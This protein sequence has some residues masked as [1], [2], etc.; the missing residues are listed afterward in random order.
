MDNR[1]QFPAYEDWVDPDDT[2][3]PI[4][5]TTNNMNLKDFE[6]YTD[7]KEADIRRLQYECCLAN[8]S[9]ETACGV[10]VEG[11]GFQDKSVKL[12]IR[13][14]TTVKAPPAGSPTTA[15]Q[16]MCCFVNVSSAQYESYQDQN[17]EVSPG[18]YSTAYV[19]NR[20]PKLVDLN[21]GSGLTY[22][23]SA[24]VKNSA[25]AGDLVIPPF[26][27]PTSVGGIVEYPLDGLGLDLTG[28]RGRVVGQEVNVVVSDNVTV[29]KGFG[30][31]WITKNAYDTDM[32]GRTIDEVF[33][34]QGLQINSAPLNDLD[35]K[36]IFRALRVPLEQ[37][38]T[39]W[40]KM[41]W[42]ASAL[43]SVNRRNILMS[44]PWGG[45][46][47]YGCAE[48]QT[49]T[50]VTHTVIEIAGNDYS[51]ATRNGAGG[52]PIE[53]LSELHAGVGAHI[54]HEDDI[55][56]QTAAIVASSQAA[57]KGPRHAKGF[58]DYAAEAPGMVGE[59]ADKAGKALEAGD[60]IMGGL[61]SA[62]EIIGDILGGLS[63]FGLARIQ[64]KSDA[65]K[66]VLTHG[67][68][69]N[70]QTY[71]PLSGIPPLRFPSEFKT[72]KQVAKEQADAEK[73]GLTLKEF[74][75]ED[76]DAFNRI[77]DASSQKPGSELPPLGESPTQSRCD[78]GGTH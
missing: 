74:P 31:T 72:P 59:I 21:D 42:S 41:D 39:N 30:F 22:H 60:A 64:K 24:Q 57:E 10:Y 70:Q 20:L 38:D 48:D 4:G 23:S 73:F 69:P 15:G 26:G 18:V 6:R 27:D 58:L 40:C 62:G 1:T 19:T 50:V 34:T 12:F 16:V 56:A 66:P 11:S 13:A 33:G 71:H 63:I 49:F 2:G 47:A 77:L 28:A 37:G 68:T 32:H 35:N 44:T 75:P 8:P 76:Q 53:G 54:I 65:G 5:P 25:N 9:A 67:E 52:M 14:T 3:M 7:P 46:C 51:F 78:C 61:D 43:P 36:H 45:F 55:D 17:V 29:K